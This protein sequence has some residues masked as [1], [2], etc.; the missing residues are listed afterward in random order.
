MGFLLEIIVRKK[1]TWCS[2][3]NET[4]NTILH[5]QYGYDSGERFSPFE[6]NRK[7]AQVCRRSVLRC[8]LSSSLFVFLR[9]S[10][11]DSH[12][13]RCDRDRCWLHFYPKRCDNKT[14]DHCEWDT[15]VRTKRTY[16]A[17]KLSKWEIGEIN[18][19]EVKWHFCALTILPSVCI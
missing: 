4:K 6:I 13:T 1:K 14:V 9:R 15:R 16:R 19:V 10:P 11:H 2:C 5:F 3:S 17:Q 18:W 12:T 8:Q 7:Y